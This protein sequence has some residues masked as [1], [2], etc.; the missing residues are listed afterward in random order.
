M[1]AASQLTSGASLLHNNLA[2]SSTGYVASIHNSLNAGQGKLLLHALA[3]GQ[4]KDGPEVV[5]ATSIR[6]L[7]TLH[8]PVLVVTSTNGTQVYTEDA[9][10]LIFFLPLS[11]QAGPDSI[12]YHQAACFVPTTQHMVI[13][14]SKGTIWPV[15]A[16]AAGQY[17]QLHES[18]PSSPTA[19]VSDLCFSPIADAVVSVH[20]NGDLRLWQVSEDAPYTN[21]D[22][23]ANLCQAPVRVVSLGAQLAVADGPGSIFILDATTRELKAEVT[24][25]G[26]WLSAAVSRED[27]GLLVT[28]GED[29]VLN[30]WQVDPSEGIVSLHHSTV[31]A[32]KLLCGVALHGSGASVVA[33]DSD[34][35]YHVNF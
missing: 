26:R 24:A 20:N 9:S 7:E 15:S 18:A 29:T 30:V 31:V 23:V 19:E 8:G 25:H 14:T 6:Y 32:D 34:Q 17:V 22:V 3:S 13:G 1:A 28:V 35:L 33:Y 27:I 12:R 10:A 5:Q 21:S 16:V 11:D 4:S 2:S